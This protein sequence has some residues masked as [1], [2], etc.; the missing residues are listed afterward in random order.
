MTPGAQS[1][2]ALSLPLSPRRIALLAGL[3]ALSVA[4]LVTLGGGYEVLAALPHV[5]WR[6]VGLAALIHL[7]G[8]GLRGLRWRQ[9]LAMA[10]YPLRWRYVTTLLLAGWFVSALLPARAGDLVRVGVLRLGKPGQPP[11]PVAAALGS[12]VLERVLDLLAILA[13]GIGFGYVALGAQLPP[14]VRAAYLAGA[15]VLALFVVAMLVM[16]AFFHRLE[17][18]SNRPL[19]QRAVNFAAH[20]AESL[21][22]LTRHPR[23]AGVVVGE[24]L[25]IWL[26]DALLLWLAVAAAGPR[27]PFGA[28]AFVAL[29]VDVT[30]AVPLT[31]GGVG[32]IE[33]VNAA[34]LATFGLA[35]AHIAVAVLVTRAVSYWG[36]L[37]FAGAV[38]FGAGF[39][40]LLAKPGAE[41]DEA[42]LS[43][44]HRDASNVKRQS[45]LDV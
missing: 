43:E 8:F 16:P 13:L 12:I 17:R 21:A 37:F 36:F 1:P 40:Q 3:G 6:L 39:G 41:G 44:A 4:L 31:P 15:G 32:Q 30:A 45:T 7:G 29:T 42:T 10:G 22:I 11:A 5:D 34:L 26:C 14:W 25:L 2:K 19:W 33:A 28:A 35:P 27:L 9:L 20:L 18:L 24:S 38:T 23:M